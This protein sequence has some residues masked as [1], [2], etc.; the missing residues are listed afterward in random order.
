[1]V[2]VLGLEGVLM[3]DVVEPWWSHLNQEW[4]LKFDKI[5]HIKIKFPFRFGRFN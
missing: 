2:G 1:M 4:V 3:F 5:M